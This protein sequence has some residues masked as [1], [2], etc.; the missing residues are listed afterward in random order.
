MAKIAQTRA[1]KVFS[2]S[3]RHDQQVLKDKAKAEQARADK[4]AR[5]RELRL[6][7]DAAEAEE[8]AAEAEATEVAAKASKPPVKSS[9]KRKAAS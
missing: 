3:A 8:A 4:M 5:L 2:T 7:R 9:R 1:E 6:A